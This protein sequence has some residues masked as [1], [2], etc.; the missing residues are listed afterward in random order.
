MQ[1]EM[2]FHD[3]TVIA[4]SRDGSTLCI[5]FDAYVHRWEIIEGE[6]KG[7]GWAQP[8]KIAMLDAICTHTP[9]LPAD[10]D[11]GKLETAG[12]THSDM[13]PLPFSSSESTTLTLFLATATP[14]QF[15]AKDILIQAEGP[16][17]QI[18][19]LPKDF[20]PKNLGQQSVGGDA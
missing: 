7:S 1:T 4:I 18:D 9:R 17:R 3:S 6:W 5:H 10:L 2:E 12:A 8:V 19:K 16:G 15:K 20:K 11:G 13:V 14:V